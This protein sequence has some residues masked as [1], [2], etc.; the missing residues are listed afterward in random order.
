MRICQIAFADD[1]GGAERVAHN[2]HQSYLSLG[3]DAFLAVGQRFSLDPTVIPLDNASLRNP[4]SRF[5][6][7]LA[8]SLGRSGSIRRRLRRLAELLA[9][10]K[11]CLRRLAGHEDFDH[12]AAARLAELLPRTPQVLHAHNLHG[13]YFD[14]RA[15]ASLS[16][17]VP[18]FWTLHDMWSFTGGC[19]HSLDCE[20]WRHACGNCPRVRR[21]GDFGDRTADNRELKASIYRNCRLYVAAPSRWL[22]AKATGSILAPAIVDARCIP[23]GVDTET[24]TPGDGRAARIRLGLPPNA[25][26][27]LAAGRDLLTNP[28]KDFATVSTAASAVARRE[29]GRPVILLVAGTSRR[30]EH[31]GPLEI[32]YVGYQ[33]DRSHM[34]DCYRAADVFL[35]A[36]HVEN[37]PNVILEAMACARP[38][39]ATAVGG[40]P[41]QVTDGRTGLLVPAHDAD[42][43]VECIELLLA[44]EE[45][46]QQMGRAAMRVVRRRYTLQVQAT[47]Y[48]AWYQEA[49]GTAQEAPAKAARSGASARV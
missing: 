15:L 14:L 20:G 36:A 12:P 23:N 39:I 7:R 5:W 46:R 49:I 35:H 22:L 10:P 4:W 33:K 29:A 21:W 24:F 37:F 11:A 34:A 47:A 13:N 32:R 30:A 18:T 2:L 3:E 43:L 16:Q 6:C 25:F 31:H 27:L 45:R 9:R 48:R 1:A 8:D 42:A 40:I 28:W 17:R 44:N 19:H 38:V 26:I 41:E